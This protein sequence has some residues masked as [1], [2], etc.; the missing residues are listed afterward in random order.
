M[1]EKNATFLFFVKHLMVQPSYMTQY[2]EF[3]FHFTYK[4]LVPESPNS[5]RKTFVCYF[6]VHRK[7]VF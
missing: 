4:V 1:L 3:I 6:K 7:S 2:F 5:A